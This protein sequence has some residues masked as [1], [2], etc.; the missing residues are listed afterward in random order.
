MAAAAD[1]SQAAGQAFTNIGAKW[2]LNTLKNAVTLFASDCAGVFVESNPN[3][4]PMGDWLAIIAAI[5][6]DMPSGGAP[7]QP[8]ISFSQMQSAAKAVGGMCSLGF[9]LNASLLITNAQAAAVLAAYNAR[10]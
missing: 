5:G 9:Q 6:Q 7:T 10:F 1:L 4:H 2:N 8:V 3:D